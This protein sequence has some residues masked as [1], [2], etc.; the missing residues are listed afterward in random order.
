M[1][2]RAERKL[3]L[4]SLRLCVFAGNTSA[5]PRAS[6]RPIGAVV[7]PHFRASFAMRSEED[8]MDIEM[9]AREAVGCGYKVHLEI[10]PGLL[11]SV[12]EQLLA[13][14]LEK[15]GLRIVR[16][17]SISFEYDGVVLDDAFR[18]DLLVEDCLLIEVKSAER[19]AAVQ[20]KQTLTYLRLMKLPLGLLMNFGL[21]TFKEGVQRIANSY[22]GAGSTSGR[23]RSNP[24]TLVPLPGGR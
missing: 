3:A 18:A 5:F 13:R 6:A 17:K 20:I 22:D 8:A 12:Y 21:P 11:E 9:L 14:L 7:R 2:L 24:I 4:T 16:Q 10:G 15:R 19:T 1:A 23:A